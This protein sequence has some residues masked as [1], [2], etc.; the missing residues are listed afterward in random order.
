MTRLVLCGLMLMTCLLPAGCGDGTPPQGDATDDKLRIAV[1]PKG[2]TH[3]FWRSVYRG[4]REAADELGV[5]I[6]WRGPLEENDRA[7]QIQVVQQFTSQRVDGI[8]LAPLDSHALRGPVRAANAAN[9]PVVIFDSALEGEPGSDFVSFVATNN[10]EGGRLGGEEL[11]RQLNGQGKVAMLR[12][13]AG[14]ASTLAREQGFMDVIEPHDGIEIIVSNRY[15][16]A[17]A[18]QA[19][20]EALNMIDRLREADGV[21]A[22]NESATNG[23]LQAMRRENLARDRVFVGFDASPPLVQALRNGEIDALVVQ[24]PRYMGY[25]AVKTMVAH[26][27]GEQV[28]QMIDT[29]VVV[30]TRDN[31]DDPDIQP[32]IE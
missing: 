32:L 3:V 19:Q 25:M 24:N 20:T 7:M 1:I 16:G 17:T 2:T 28:E 23:L 22:S 9:I 30:V 14:S 26:L 11:A 8:V 10:V 6:I 18:G 12:Y 13:M 5:D 31:I 21:F 4:A 29:G 27:R 15:A